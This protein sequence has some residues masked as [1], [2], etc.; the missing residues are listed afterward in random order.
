MVE[1][2]TCGL[3]EICWAAWTTLGSLTFMLNSKNKIEEKKNTEKQRHQ[4]P[5]RIR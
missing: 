4:I 1:L 2:K 3:G 5:G